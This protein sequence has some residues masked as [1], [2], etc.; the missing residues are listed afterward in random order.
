MSPDL[1]SQKPEKI[2]TSPETSVEYV[3]GFKLVLIVSSVALACFLMLLD[4]M[5]IGTL[6]SCSAAPQPLTGKIYTSFN[7]KVRI[8][9]LL[10]IYV[11]INANFQWTFLVF[12]AIFEIG[13]ILCGAAISSNMLI[14]GR[15]IAGF[16]ASGIINGA[17][18]I[19]SSCVPLEKRPMNQLG[20]V[21]GPL[22]GGA[23]TSYTTWRWSFFLL[24]LSIPEQTRKPNVFVVLSKLHHHLDLVGFILFAP[25]ILQ[26][27]LAFQYGA[28]QYPWNSPRVIGLFCGFAANFA[29]WLFWNRYK[30]DDA[31]LPHSMLRLKP[32]WT[33]AFYQAFMISAVYGASF[34]LP[35]Y[36][37]AINNATPVLSG[38]YLLPTILPQLVAAGLSGVL[39]VAGTILLSLGSGFY[40]ILQP[41]SPTGYWIGFQ[42]LA[43][44]GSGISMQ[45]AIITIQAAVSGEQLATGM[46]LVIFAQSLG[47]AIMLVLCNVIF[48]SSLGSQLHEHAP[49]ANSA[50]IIKAGA[51][52]FRSIVQLEDLPGVLI[53][54]ANIIDRIFYLVAAVGAACA[55]VLWGM[56]W[57]DLRKRDG[58]QRSEED[59]A[60]KGD[61]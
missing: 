40:S 6:T 41:G 56:G 18:T 23:F 2:D 38:V 37:Q 49:N 44:I 52:G 29:L 10:Y 48:L 35:I 19:I 55:L 15:A 46:A 57:H 31:L 54:Y 7:S 11:N 53:A 13:S 16:G 30:G 61:R 28:N 50:A 3:T 4:T 45:L 47:P 20:L 33:S 43:G 1:D 14:V 59:V 60:E 32:V 42:L 17:I 24:F 34:F 22:V 39:S 36:F 21:A 25:A 12:F 8:Y 26:L 5:V 27:L 9:W 58:K 51:T